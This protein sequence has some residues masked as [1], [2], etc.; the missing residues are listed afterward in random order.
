M[1]G[2]RSVSMRLACAFIAASAMSMCPLLLTFSGAD[3]LSVSIE[4]PLAADIVAGM[5][6]LSGNSTQAQGV[7]LSID[8]GT[9][10]N[11]SGVPHWHYLWNSTQVPSGIHSVQARAYNGSA[12]AASSVV[13]FTVNNTPPTSLEITLELSPQQAFAGEDFIASGMAQFDSGVR[14]R[15]GTVQV[16]SANISTNT[17]TDSRGYYSAQMAAPLFPGMTAVRAQT[18]SSGLSGT[19]LAYLDIIFRAPPD[20]SVSADNITFVPPEPSGGDEVTIGAIISNVGGTNASSTVRFSSSGHDPQDIDVDVAAGGSWPASVKWRL[21]SGRHAIQVSLLDTTPY[22]A[23]YSN[24]N[25][26]REL[27]VL[28][29][30]DIAVTAMVFSNSRPT[31]GMTITVQA[32]ISNTGEISASGSVT[33]YDGRPPGGASLGSQRVTVPA[34]STLTVFLNWNATRGT[35][36]ITAVATDVLPE[37]PDLSDNELTR[38][39]EVSKK[40]SP[41][42]NPTPGLQ[43]APLLAA[44]VLLA[45]LRTPGKRRSPPGG[46]SAGPQHNIF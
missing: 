28:A 22:D 17:T 3:S 39:L 41:Q 8:S 13:Q 23:N 32:R 27:H 36:N 44:V 25:A 31:E 14:G 46:R 43:A 26:S 1:L 5:V 12:Y 18:S 30:P 9:W 33:L 45:L 24:D 19:A 4:R 7:Q 29:S 6:E 40:S 10:W 11:A 34:N 15:G 37:D 2:Q 21:P 20:L 35:H 38:Q 16:I 42:A